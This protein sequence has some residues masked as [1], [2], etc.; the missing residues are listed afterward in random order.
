MGE[1]YSWR[2]DFGLKWG[3]FYVCSWSISR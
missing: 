1:S 3:L 2:K